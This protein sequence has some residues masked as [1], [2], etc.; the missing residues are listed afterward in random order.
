MAVARS[1]S[2]V[3]RM[4]TRALQTVFVIAIVAALLFPIYCIVQMCVGGYKSIWDPLISEFTLDSFIAM[5]GRQWATGFRNSVIISLA[6]AA[7]CVLIAIPAAY[8]FTRVNFRFD[9]HL[10]FF[11]IMQRMLPPGAF[12]IPVFM[13][14]TG[15][16]LYDTLPGVILAH[17]IFNL[18]LAVW[19]LHGFMKD[20]PTTVDEAAFVDGYS[21]WGFWRRVFLPLMMPAI[22]VTAFFLWMFSWT[23]LILANAVTRNASYPITVQLLLSLGTMTTGPMYKEAAAAGVLSMIPG[24]VVLFFARRYIAR[25]FLLGGRPGGV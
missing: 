18:P 17:S 12:I 14:Y 6:N 8:M 16:G 9:N 5:G 23:E 4:V 21:V 1:P 25:G 19:I 7:F 10:F 15:I 3:R 24:V 11:T 22:G 20:I 2:R 13:I